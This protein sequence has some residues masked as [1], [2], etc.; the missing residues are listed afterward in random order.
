MQYHSS[1]SLA[2]LPQTWILKSIQWVLWKRKN[3]QVEECLWILSEIMV[4]EDRGATWLASIY[5]GTFKPS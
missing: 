4:S 3:P 2:G 1:L 5:T